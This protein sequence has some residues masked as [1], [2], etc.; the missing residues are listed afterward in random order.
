M[1]KIDFKNLP[2][3][4]TPLSASNLNTLQD[5]VESAI[6]EKISNSAGTSQTIGYSQ[7][8]INDSLKW[9]LVQ[10]VSG[11]TQ[12]TLPSSWNEILVVA[13]LN[14]DT[15]KNFT[16]IIPYGAP[17]DTHYRLSYYGTSNDNVNIGYYYSSSNKINMGWFN[18]NNVNQSANGKTQVYYR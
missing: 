9:K 16:L 3:T 5:N 18:V 14:G 7:K 6:N 17:T 2:D 4:S 11:Q 12:I 8:Y 13:W 10:E 1:N 15:F